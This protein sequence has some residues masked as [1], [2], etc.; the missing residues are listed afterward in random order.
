MLPATLPPAPIAASIG[1]PD[2]SKGA[3]VPPDLQAMLDAAMASGN[4]AEV[5]TIAKYA[6]KAAPAS[7]KTINDEVVAWRDAR[8]RAHEAKVE[9]ADFLDLWTGKATLGGWLTTG[10]SSNKGV[11]GSLDLDREGLQWRHK[12]HLQIDYQESLGIETREHYLASYEPNYKIDDRAYI[13]GSLQFESD[14]FSGYYD[15][16][17]TSF[18]GGYSAI[19]NPSTRLDLELG[20]AYRYTDFT[21]DTR[22]NGVAARGSLDF[23]WKLSHAIS[24]SQQAAAYLESYNSTVTG[25]TAL[26][27]KLFGPLSAQLSYNFQYES[28]PPVGAV[29]TDTTS[30]ASLVYSF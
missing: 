8:T 13:Y 28:M 5:G 10:N 15:R 21:D 23:N 22:E 26:N 16:Y 14:K 27:A 30:R 25:T 20:P 29:S 12:V 18:G 3:P 1:Q 9:A 6:G 17:S 4:D 19:K 2:I 24:V 7:A 11:S